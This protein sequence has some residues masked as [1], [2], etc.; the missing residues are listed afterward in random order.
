MNPVSSMRLYDAEGL[1]PKFRNEFPELAKIIRE[2][3]LCKY[4]L[5]CLLAHSFSSS[6]GAAFVRRVLGQ[7][8][9]AQRLLNNISRRHTAIVGQTRS[10]KTYATRLF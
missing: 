4:Q 1:V 5:P 9:V 6:S 10:G 8:M 3:N 2:T 7:I